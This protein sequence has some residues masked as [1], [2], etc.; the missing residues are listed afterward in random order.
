MGDGGQKVKAYRYKINN[1]D[2]TY[3]TVTTVN[4]VLHILKLLREE[5]LKVLII[6]KKYHNYVW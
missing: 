5:I 2:V 4:T 1:G 6:R 3:S